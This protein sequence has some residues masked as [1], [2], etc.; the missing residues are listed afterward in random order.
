MKNVDDVI[1]PR[2]IDDAIPGSL[3]L[4]AQFKNA[5]ANQRQ[6][7]VIAGPFALLQLPKLESEV[8]SYV[9]REGLGNGPGVALPSDC[10]IFGRFSWVAHKS[11]Y[12]RKT[13]VQIYKQM[14]IIVQGKLGTYRK[15]ASAYR[16][17]GMDT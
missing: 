14:Y 8:L 10:R 12:I 9:L 5:R 17:C 3:I 4:I 6:R 1:D 13:Q 7:P 11:E 2:Q 16:C 15:S